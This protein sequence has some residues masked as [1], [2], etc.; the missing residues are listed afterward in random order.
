MSLYLEP[1]QSRDYELTSYERQLALE[2]ERAFTGGADTPE[3]VAAGLNRN[4]VPGPDGGPW[5]AESF[6]AEMAR[7]GK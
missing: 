6:I 3:S 4:D 1:T 7:L 5:T 2:I